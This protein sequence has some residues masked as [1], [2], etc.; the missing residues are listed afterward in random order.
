MNS[1]GFTSQ[2]KTDYQQAIWRCL[3]RN[4]TIVIT[5]IADEKLVV[6]GVDNYSVRR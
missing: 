5:A 6:A 2:E 4:L 1:P 3:R